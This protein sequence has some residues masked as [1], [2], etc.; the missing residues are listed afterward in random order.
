MTPGQ[1]EAPVGARQTTGIVHRRSAVAVATTVARL[2]E[3]INTVGAKLFAVID[4]SGEAERA[5]LSLRDTKVVVFGNPAAGT[6]VMEASPL[7]ALDLPLKVLVWEDDSGAVW[8]SYLSGQWLAERHGIP[9]D[10]AK[11]LFA[12]DVL[13]AL[14]ASAR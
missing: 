2:T 5:G 6:P 13:T 10:L 4:H 7:A 1:P 12:V 8:M 11:P 9:T 14:V 3:A